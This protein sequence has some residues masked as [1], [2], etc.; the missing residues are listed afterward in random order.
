M[1]S[2][3]EDKLLEYA[4]R[5]SLQEQ[6]SGEG[7]TKG[8]EKAVPREEKGRRGRDK[9]VLPEKTPAVNKPAVFNSAQGECTACF[10]RGMVM[11]VPCGCKYCLNCLARIFIQAMEEEIFLQPQCCGRILP[12]DMV[13][14][15][16]EELGI[17]KES[18]PTIS[19]KVK[20]RNRGKDRT[21]A[22]SK[23]KGK[24]KAVI[25][26]ANTRPNPV[27]CLICMDTFDEK[28]VI[29]TPCQH[30]YCHGCMNRLFVEATR[31]E[32][33]YPPKCCNKEIPLTVANT[34]LNAQ[35]QTE[36]TTKGSEFRTKDRLYCSSQYCS[37]FIHPSKIKS[38]VGT[39]SK[40]LERTCVHCKGA[41]H[42]GD[43]PKDKAT[44]EVLKL[45]HNNGWRRCYSCKAMV[46]LGEG[47]NHIRCG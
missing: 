41:Y 16:L 24:G 46:E 12:T 32:S 47:C 1:E 7:S 14:P 20:S 9:N 10:D 19:A 25:L 31:N 28:E 4:L 15:I 26:E 36:F 35:Q 38:D 42:R 30:Y 8:K 39:C 44:Q 11:Q 27:D 29:K 22:R 34:V 2:E 40:C 13:T 45:A 6:G 33:L 23:G 17:S 43:C 5:L 37:A 18:S 3:I 21:G